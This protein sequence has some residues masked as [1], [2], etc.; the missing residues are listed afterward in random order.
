MSETALYDGEH[1]D[2]PQRARGAPEAY[3][4][5]LG[6]LV[7]HA[8]R[9]R[10]QMAREKPRPSDSYKGGQHLDKKP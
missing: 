4:V 7:M 5:P 1:C 9:Q 8:V 2:L 10:M 3:G 6:Q